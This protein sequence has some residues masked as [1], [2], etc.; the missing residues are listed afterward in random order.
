[1]AMISPKLHITFAK[2]LAPREGFFVF[3][4]INSKRVRSCPLRVRTHLN[5]KKNLILC[6]FQVGTPLA[7]TGA[8]HE[9]HIIVKAN[10]T[11]LM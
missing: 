1:M 7:I 11:A 2:A 6:G 3:G 10:D 4:D 9:P 8:T 5:D